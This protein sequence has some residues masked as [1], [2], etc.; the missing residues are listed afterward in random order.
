MP[1]T[2]EDITSNLPNDARLFDKLR[3]RIRRH[4]V[5]S[6]TEAVAV[7]LWIVHTHAFDNF[8]FTPR[9][10]VTSP[11]RGC[12]KTTLMSFLSYIVR[13]GITSLVSPPAVYREI[14]NSQATLLI[15]EADASFVEKQLITILNSGFQR[16]SAYVVRAYGSSGTQRYITWAPAAYAVLDEIPDNLASR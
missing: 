2:E 6:D 11:E 5:M 4:I 7:V 16:D 13:S 15:D 9:L 10:G 3:R 12:G 8:R 14:E 1:K